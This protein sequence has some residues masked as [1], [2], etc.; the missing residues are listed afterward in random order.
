MENPAP[1]EKK[2]PI[3]AEGNPPEALG[4]RGVPRRE[5]GVKFWEVSNLG[6]SGMPGGGP[7]IVRR[8]DRFC[9]RVNDAWASLYW[10]SSFS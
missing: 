8:Q 5:V 2:V 6:K 1:R 4:C 7:T 10:W 3:P 9:G